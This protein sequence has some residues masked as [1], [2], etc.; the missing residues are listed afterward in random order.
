ME[1]ALLEEADMPF[2]Q[3]FVQNAEVCVCV[4]VCAGAPLW[5][6]AASC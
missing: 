5:P 6:A 3:R 1:R 2:A 4:C